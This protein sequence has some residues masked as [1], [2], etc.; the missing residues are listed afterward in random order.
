MIMSQADIC[1]S[2]VVSDRLVAELFEGPVVGR[3]GERRFLRNLQIVDRV[4]LFRMN[5]AEMKTKDFIDET[6]KTL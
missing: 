2:P 6:V 3:P 1:S 4:E 5:D